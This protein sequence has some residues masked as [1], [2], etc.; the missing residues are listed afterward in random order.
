MSKKGRLLLLIP[1]LAVIIAAIFNIVGAA[2]EY[3]GWFQG[4]TDA[5]EDRDYYFGWKG[6]EGDGIR[7]K[8]EYSDELF[9]SKHLE[10]TGKAVVAFSALAVIAN[11]SG[12]IF[13]ILGIIIPSKV[14]LR[15][16]A[17]AF[18]GLCLA[19]AA[20]C[21][22]IAFIVFICVFGSETTDDDDSIHAL[23]RWW[24][25]YA[26]FFTLFAFMFD[27]FANCCIGGFGLMDRE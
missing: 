3:E 2:S 10:S 23:D 19:I 5:F 22:F 17:R 13:L 14:S 21:S 1:L 4:Y 6:Y 26:W 7:D 12:A 25:S 18:S 9:H 15:K 24:P 20:M 27:L 16:L 11:A 8:I